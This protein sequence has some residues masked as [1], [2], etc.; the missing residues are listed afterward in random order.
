MRNRRPKR[1]RSK[2]ASQHG[3]VQWQRGG[4]ITG[5]RAA[6]WEGVEA[7]QR[8]DG[9]TDDILLAK[10]VKQLVKTHQQILANHKISVEKKEEQIQHS[11]IRK[12]FGL[13]R[14]R[15]RIHCQLK[16]EISFTF[17]LLPFSLFLSSLV[18][19]FGISFLFYEFFLSSN[20]N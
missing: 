8:D 12:V 10:R 2:S 1:R 18:L 13:A 20:I 9:V 6:E 17:Y 4:Q 16:S 7:Q 15:T 5:K 11:A 3:E 19:S 14:V